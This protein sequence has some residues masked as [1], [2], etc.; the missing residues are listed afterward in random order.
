MRDQ[1]FS[2]DTIFALS[3]GSLPSGVAVIRISGPQC[4]AIWEELCG[5]EPQPRRAAYVALRDTDNEL[6]DRG[7]GIFFAG[8]ASFTGEDCVE[9]QVHGSKA[10][11]AKLLS[12]LSAMPGLRAAEAGEFTRRAYMNGKLDLANV[13]ALSDL[14]AAETETQRRFAIASSSGRHREIYDSWRAK[15]I[16]ARALI[17]AELDFADEADVPG[18]VSDR[19]W[20]DVRELRGRI[21][22]HLSAYHH[23]EIIREGL[24]VVILGAPNAGKSS[25]MNVLAQRD[26][27]IVTDEAGTTRD[28]LEVHLDL[29]GLKVNLA[30]TA[31][32]R[33]TPGKVEAI[34]IQR[35]LDRASSAD[36]VLLVED[37]A[38]PVM[39]PG[40]PDVPTIRVGN[41]AD[42][43]TDTKCRDYDCVI[44]TRT[45][46]GI[47]RLI[48]SLRQH[49]DQYTA[50]AGSI[51]PFRERHKVLLEEALAHLD[52]ALEESELE[53]AAE[54]MRL[55]SDALGRICGRID[56]EDLLD[57]IFARFCIGK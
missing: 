41:K 38:N 2:T 9:L 11:V 43:V 35:S 8:P 57:T 28:V 10:V 6:I 12:T 56:V 53:L 27:A 44:S 20:K 37:M 51:I 25:L 24:Q 48:S 3:S 36:L 4:R 14:I 5:S 30:D 18:S 39:V 47:D 33:E 22:A 34:G 13:E 46:E 45:G 50:S 42:L 1:I 19:V 52:I 23:A 21:S 16:E 7:I 49:A 40:L 26:V 55:A 17:E 32:L 15:L 29:G 31:G 54:R